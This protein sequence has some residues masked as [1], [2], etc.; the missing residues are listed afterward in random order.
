MGFKITCVSIVYSTVCSDADQRKHQFRVTG[1]CEGNS[2]VTNEFPAQRARNAENVSIW[3]RHHGSW[4]GVIC[5]IQNFHDSG[6]TKPCGFVVSFSFRI[7]TPGHASHTSCKATVEM[8]NSETIT[9]AAFD[10]RKNAHLLLRL[11]IN[12]L[13]LLCCTVYGHFISRHL[14]KCPNRSARHGFSDRML[15]A[16][17]SSSIMAP[18]R[19]SLP[20]PITT[21][22]YQITG[23]NATT[24]C[25][26]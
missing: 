22:F 3:W 2:P 15:L 7:S 20:A 18:F 1:L 13:F 19:P 24:P 23:R 26:S 16:A 10:K 21:I 17:A 4:L 14:E 25:G 11:G 12:A 9:V 5:E 6:M 8:H